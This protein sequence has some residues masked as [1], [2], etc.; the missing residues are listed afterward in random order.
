MREVWGYGV[1]S[2]AGPGEA[3]ANR[4]YGARGGVSAVGSGTR[5][6]PQ[7]KEAATFPRLGNTEILISENGICGS[8]LSE[9]K[10]L[11]FLVNGSILHCYYLNTHYPAKRR[12]EA[13]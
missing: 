1:D 9:T 7:K 12:K 3:L 4:R 5:S 10:P 6:E 2:S 13:H 11:R 8:L